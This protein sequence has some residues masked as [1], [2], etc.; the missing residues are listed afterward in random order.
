MVR[1]HVV[2]QHRLDRRGVN[3]G[4]G[5][6]RENLAGGDAH[7]GSMAKDH[8]LAAEQ[9]LKHGKLKALVATASLELGIDIGDVDLVC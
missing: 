5:D 8:R 7:H 6:V 1:V 3:A 9:K 4:G 2:K